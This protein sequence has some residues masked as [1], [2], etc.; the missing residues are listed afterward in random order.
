MGIA[1]L[2]LEEAM[3]ALNASKLAFL[4]S[5]ELEMES[6]VSST[7]GGGLTNKLAL[8]SEWEIDLFGRLSNA[9]KQNAEEL[10][11]SEAYVQAVQTQLI[12][13]VAEMYYSLILLDKQLNV[14]KQTVANWEE[15]V[16]IL[17]ALMVAG[18]SDLVA[19]SMARA[20]LLKAQQSMVSLE[21]E[22]FSLENFFSA[23][24][25]IVPQRIKRGEC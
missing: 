4:P 24:L 15:T 21:K 3:A 1:R 22:I 25:G 16:N 8:S 6:G 17:S 19:V 12:A 14:T 23:L 5:L 20:S 10:E 13:H 2:K 18:E 11:R 7:G 9:K